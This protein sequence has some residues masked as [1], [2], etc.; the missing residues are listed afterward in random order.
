MSSSK[1]KFRNLEAFR[2]KINYKVIIDDILKAYQHMGCVF[3]TH[4]LYFLLHSFFPNLNAVTN[5]GKDST[6][7]WPLR[8]YAGNSAREDVSRLLLERHT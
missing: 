2:Y 6:R 4:F 1:T 5:T 3:E 7:I 8:S